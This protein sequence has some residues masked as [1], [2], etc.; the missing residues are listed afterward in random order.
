MDTIPYNLNRFILA[1]STQ[2]ERALNEIKAGKKQSH[3]M[4][5][6]FP[7]LKGLGKSVKSNVYG[8]ENLEEAQHYLAHAVLGVRLIEITKALLNLNGLSAKAIFDSP[9]DLK[10]K[11]SMT[12]FALA[13]ASKDNLFMNVLEKY[14][15]KN[16]DERT[17]VML[18]KNQRLNTWWFFR[19]VP[20][21]IKIDFLKSMGRRRL[22]GK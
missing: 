14:Y 19:N 3:W 6:I 15:N 2:Y 7:Q 10:L 11:S 20:A 9:D 4:W 17:K 21:E 12:L 16:M 5:Y 1:Q 18:K 8:I 22:R 13:E